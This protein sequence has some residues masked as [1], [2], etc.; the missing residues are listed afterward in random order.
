[1]VTP[2]QASNVLSA[3]VN[4]FLDSDPIPKDEPELPIIRHAHLIHRIPQHLVVLKIRTQSKID[5]T[6]DG[7]SFGHTCSEM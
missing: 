1:M 7:C 4:L 2:P 5:D 3:L 6:L